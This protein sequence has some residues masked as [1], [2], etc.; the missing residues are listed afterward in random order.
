MTATDDIDDGVLRAWLLHRPLDPLTTVALEQR[1]LEDDTLG[2]RLQAIETDLIDDHARGALDDDDRRAVQRWLLATPAD[3]TRWRTALALARAIRATPHQAT[4]GP[5]HATP[6]PLREREAR[7][8]HRAAFAFA[9]AACVLLAV[10]VFRERDERAHSTGDVSSSNRTIT[11]LASRQRGARA[12][13][14]AIVTLAP[15]ASAVRLQVEVLEGD[16]RARYTLTISDASRPVFE[17]HD[18]APKSVGAYR[19]VEAMI[20]PDIWRPGELHVRVAVGDPPRTLQEWS[21]LARPR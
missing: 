8:P 20:A 12:E 16:A 9:A 5:A 7:R 4:S 17:V 1:V 21:V 18:L 19:F 11:L 10:L 14:D 15:D 13:P 3:R 2:A 6:R